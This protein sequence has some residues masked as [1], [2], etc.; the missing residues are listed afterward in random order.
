M[1]IQCLLID[2]YGRKGLLNNSFELA[3]I[4]TKENEYYDSIDSI[5]LNGNNCNCYFMT[6]L[7]AC[8]KYKNI[9]LGQKVFDILKNSCINNNNNLTY[10]SMMAAASVAI[11]DIYLTINDLES[12]DEINSQRIKQGWKKIPGISQT[13]I[14]GKIYSFTAGNNYKYKYSKEISKLMD[15]KLDEWEYKL[16]DMFDFKHNKSCLTKKLDDNE[17]MEYVL[18]RHSEKLALAFN[19]ISINNNNKNESIYINKNLR[20]CQNCHNA[21]KLISKIENRQIR[22]AD[23]KVLHDFDGNGNC[24]C[25]DYH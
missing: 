23:A 17:T 15:N 24:S 1:R 11:Q 6:V 7:A 16:K 19:F 25:N 18:C 8:K 13:E 5:Q 4:F 3:T 20:M 14:N 2:V 21:T 12:K 22:V 9:E 10:Q